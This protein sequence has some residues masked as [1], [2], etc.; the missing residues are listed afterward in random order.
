MGKS[1]DILPGFSMEALHN[2]DERAFEALFLYFYPALCYFAESIITDSAAA[3]DIAGETMLKAWVK[4]TT[5]ESLQHVKA[6]LYRAVRNSCF[7]FL[8][9]SARSAQRHRTFLDEQEE[10]G[11]LSRIVETEML[12]RLYNA[13]NSLPEQCRKVIRMSYIEG[14]KAEEIAGQM[15]VSVSTIKA[16]KARGIILLKKKLPRDLLLLLLSFKPF[17]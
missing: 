9:Q 11:F 6:F 16:Q 5:F 8:K 15:K 14:M 7:D 2:G 3:Q 17:L 12:A 10:T 13:I 1:M 4:R